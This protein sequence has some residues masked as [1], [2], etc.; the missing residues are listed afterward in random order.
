VTT[1]LTPARYRVRIIHHRRG[2]PDHRFSRRGRV[3]LVDITDLPTL[4]RLGRW[5]ASFRP[6]DHLDAT[7]RPLGDGVADLLARNDRPPAGRVLMLTRPRVLGYVFNPL[8]L[9][10][11]LDDC[12]QLQS[13]IAEVRNTYGGLRCYVLPVA[14]DGSAVADKDFYVSPF[15]PVDGTY[16]LRTPIPGNRLCVS[17]TLRRNERTVFTATMT[18]HRLDPRQASLWSELRT[19]LGTRAVM[20]AIRRHGMALFAKGLR[21][22]PRPVRQQ[23][24]ALP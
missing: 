14:V 7:D 24:K 23:R 3:W 10:Y 22:H 15:Y 16:R 8:S 5:L 4:P 6:G 12:G 17:V 18:G 2:D 9:L 21:P 1:A 13:I 20:W 19:P 11:C